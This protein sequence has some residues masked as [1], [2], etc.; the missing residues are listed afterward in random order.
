MEFAEEKDDKKEE[1]IGEDKAQEYMDQLEEEIEER[2][3]P[4]IKLEKERLLREHLP[5]IED[6]LPKGILEKPDPSKISTA[7]AS[8]YI[9]NH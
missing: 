6:F 7:T 1:E 3:S 4:I 9:A 8:T 2:M 5:Y